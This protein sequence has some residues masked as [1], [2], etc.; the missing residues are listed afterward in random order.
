MQWAY[1]DDV[2][3]TCVRALEAPGAVGEAFNVAHA[4]VSQRGCVEPMARIAGVEPTLVPVPRADILAAGGRLFGGNLYFGEYLDLPPIT[5]VVEKVTRRLGVTPI[6]FE[7]GLKKGFEWYL[8]QPRRAIDY[9][10][11]DRVLGKMGT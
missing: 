6:A 4:P 11:E 8:T 9:A 1:V 10:F 7:D 5:E 2:A 3:E